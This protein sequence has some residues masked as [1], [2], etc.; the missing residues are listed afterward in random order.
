MSF[1]DHLNEFYK[2]LDD[3]ANY[4]IDILSKNGFNAE[5][6]YLNGH[7]NKD[8][9]GKFVMDYYPIP[10]IDVK[11]LC[12]IE[13]VV[14]HLNI[15]TKTSLKNAVHFKY[16]KLSDYY[17]EVYGV[18]DYLADYYKSGE[19]IV[20]LYKNLEECNEKEIGFG[21]SFANNTAIDKI[22]KLVVLFRDFGFYY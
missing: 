3:K 14:T 10:V 6:S 16:D 2:N 21:F 9:N 1:R 17:Y 20:K 8:A 22:L 11:G 18:I 19:D 13:L 15:S 7:Y 5:K 12:N 4:I